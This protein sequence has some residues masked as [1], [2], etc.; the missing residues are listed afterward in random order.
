VVFDNL[1]LTPED[2]AVLETFVVPRYL[3]LFGELALDMLLRS[4][5]GARVAHLGCRVGYPD[6]QIVERIPGSTVTG[7]DPSAPA[8][9]LARNKNALHSGSAVEYLASSVFPSALSSQAFSHVLC[10]HP[11]ADASGRAE[12]FREMARL[13]YPGGQ[14]LVALPLRGSFQEIGDLFREYALKVDDRELDRAV[15]ESMLERPSIEALANEIEEAGLDDIDVEIRQTTLGFPNGRAFVEDPASRLL[16][17]PELQ[18]QGRGYS[19]EKP[20]AY[21]RDAIDKYWS[22][23]EFELTIHVGCASARQP[24]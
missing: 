10:L 8:V 2:A 7:V 15:E 23:G 9:E 3:S 5:G 4:G 19:I 13:L 16:I 24:S 21:V 12:L 11:I 14:A 17:V 1:P 18:T 22:D 20:L 6:R